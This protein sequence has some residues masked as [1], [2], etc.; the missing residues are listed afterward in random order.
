MRTVFQD[1]INSFDEL[2]K[3]RPLFGYPSKLSANKVVHQLDV[4][5][6]EF[7]QKSPFLM[8]ATS[9]ELGTCDVSPRGDAP[10]FVHIIDDHHLF[11]PER[12]GNRRMDSIRN[13]IENP[14]IGLIFIIPGIEETFRVNGM[15]C[16]SKDKDLLEKTSVNGKEP[17]FG[18]GVKIEECYVHCA[19][20]FKRSSLWKPETWLP[21]EQLP[22]A[23]KMLTYHVKSKVNIS[24]DEVCDLLDESYTKRMY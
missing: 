12:P 3:L 8:I 15:A 17:L 10:G 5:S 2:E 6:R 14:H 20:A 16:V 4:Y 22:S 9:N 21:N 18:I 13:I 11:I 24:Y 19:K 23:S 1:T 7:I